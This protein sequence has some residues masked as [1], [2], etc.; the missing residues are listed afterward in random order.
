MSGGTWEYKNLQL[1]EIADDI[2]IKSSDEDSYSIETRNIFRQMAFNTKLMAECIHNADYF[3]AGDI[4]EETFKERVEETLVKF[5]MLKL[6]TF[7]KCECCG[8][9]FTQNS[10][11]Q[12][13]CSTKCRR[14]VQ[15]ARFNKLHK[16]NKKKC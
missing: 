7:V 3:L 13:Y 6:L 1:S 14:K 5:N 12:R 15:N 16:K 8:K 9:I 11:S 4:S 10:I 2:D